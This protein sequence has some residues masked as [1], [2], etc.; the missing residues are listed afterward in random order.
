[1]FYGINNVA[2]T[3]P[4]HQRKKQMFWASNTMFSLNM[5]YNTPKHVGEI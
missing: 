2:H 3:T 1:M 4:Q 5:V